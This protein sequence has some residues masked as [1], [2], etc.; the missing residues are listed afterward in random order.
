[1]YANRHAEEICHYRG[2]GYA[3]HAPVKN[4]D[5][6]YVGNY[7]KYRGE[8]YY[9]KGNCA[10][11]EGAQYGSR[12]VVEYHKDTAAEN[13][14]DVKGGV[15]HKIFRCTHKDQD[16]TGEDNAQHRHCGGDDSGKVEGHYHRAACEFFIVAAKGLSYGYGKAV[17]ESCDKA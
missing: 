1:M 7:I 5:K 9:H 4:N 2:H 10:V 12:H 16:I 13:Y 8:N 3:C 14:G 15:G 11:A 6:N 17:G